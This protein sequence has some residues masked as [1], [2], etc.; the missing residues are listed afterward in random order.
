[1]RVLI[2]WCARFDIRARDFGDA[3]R[4]KFAPGTKRAILSF[5]LVNRAQNTPEKPW[6]TAQTALI[7]REA[8]KCK[9]PMD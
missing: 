6:T 9:Q 3:I 8:S 2:C 7:M 1:M 4:E 5:L